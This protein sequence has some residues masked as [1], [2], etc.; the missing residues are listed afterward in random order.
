MYCAQCGTELSDGAKFCVNCGTPV[1]SQKEN[2]VKAVAKQV[3]PKTNWFPKETVGKFYHHFLM[4]LS[5]ETQDYFD[6]ITSRY[7]TLDAFV[8]RGEQ[9]ITEIFSHVDAFLIGFMQIHGVYQYGEKQIAPYTHK[10]MVTGR[11]RLMLH[12]KH[13]RTLL[14]KNKECASIEKCVKLGGV[15]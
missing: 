3:Q 1:P 2:T 7:E 14:V 5:D 8:R 11:M 9:D 10:Y 13:T 6:S 4:M 12:W 15:K